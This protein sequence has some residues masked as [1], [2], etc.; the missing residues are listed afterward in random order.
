ML[1][2]A[3]SQLLEAIYQL[4]I[5]GTLQQI[6]WNKLFINGFSISKELV[7]SYWYIT[8]QQLQSIIK[9]KKMQ[10]VLMT[11]NKQKRC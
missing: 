6:Y 8:M 2:K 5:N 10:H 1:Q 9:N 3:L 11:L 4:Q 7:H